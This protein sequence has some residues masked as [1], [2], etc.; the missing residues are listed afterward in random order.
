[1]NSIVSGIV[2]HMEQVSKEIK[3]AE[4]KVDPYN[5]DPTVFSKSVPQQIQ[6]LSIL[7]R[8]YPEMSV[9][10]LSYKLQAEVTIPEVCSKFLP[11]LGQNETFLTFFL[12]YAC[13]LY[14]FSV[15]SFLEVLIQKSQTPIMVEFHNELVPLSAYNEV[16]ILSEI[17]NLIETTLSEPEKFLKTLY[18]VHTWCIFTQVATS[19]L[20]LPF[21]EKQRHF[22]AAI[23]ESL[24][25]LSLK[26]IEIFTKD[27][28]QEEIAAN[29]QVQMTYTLMARLAE[30]EVEIKS[31]T[32]LAHEKKPPT[33]A[34]S[35]PHDLQWTYY[36]LRNKQALLGKEDEHISLSD[37]VQSIPSS[38]RS[39]SGNIL[40]EPSNI[41]SKIIQ[42]ELFYYYIIVILCI[43]YR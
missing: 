34:L 1:M 12:K 38:D 42:S 14:N 7:L 31:R 37:L 4:D 22:K 15:S 32:I 41:S 19:L 3:K 24:H 6:C 28:T 27:Q 18:T 21:E 2:V 8:N 20:R 11:P 13:S 16:L 29:K 36:I 30:V 9:L 39:L 26:A 10:V 5:E 40:V 33:T 35:T 25:S 23:I 43:R 17:I